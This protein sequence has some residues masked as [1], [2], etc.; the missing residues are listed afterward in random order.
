MEKIVLDANVL[1][2]NTLRNLFLWLAR[3]KLCEAIWSS[4]LWDE[5]FRHYS[6]DP[7]VEQKFRKHVETIVFVKFANSMRKLSSGFAPIGLPDTND[8][9]VVALARQENA[10][11]VV[12]FNLKDF[13]EK[14]LSTVELKPSHPDSF[15][16]TLFD[17]FP[18]EVKA[19]IVDH[20]KALS[21]TKPSIP[22]YFESL[23]KTDVKTFV[24]KLEETAAAG[25]LFSEIWV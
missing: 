7:E 23:K 6:K 2:S 22:V 25:N 3:N 14:L 21:S 20:I 11:T 1:Y 4:E 13:P 5:V 9:H 10:A 19:S 17:N 8:E 18:D 15:L 24:K 16:C 12:T